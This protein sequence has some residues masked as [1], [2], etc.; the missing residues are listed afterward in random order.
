VIEKLRNEMYE[1]IDKFGLGDIRTVS[2]SQELDKVLN[3]E[4]TEC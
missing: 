2:K 3:E 4:G 1:Y